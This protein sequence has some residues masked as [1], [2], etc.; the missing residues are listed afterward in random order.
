MTIS[1]TQR[2]SRVSANSAGVHGVGQ[3]GGASQSSGE[4]PSEF[5]GT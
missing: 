2:N 1:R 3:G 4:T 5:A